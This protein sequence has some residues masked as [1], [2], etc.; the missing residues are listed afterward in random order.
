MLRTIVGYFVGFFV[1]VF[2]F[3][4]FINPEMLIPAAILSFILTFLLIVWSNNH[5]ERKKKQ[6]YDRFKFTPKEK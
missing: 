5:H 6:Y 3:V 2:I 4:G 1:G